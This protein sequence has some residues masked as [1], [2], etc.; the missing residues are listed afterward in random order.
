MSRHIHIKPG[1][2]INVIIS[3]YSASST[4]VPFVT[5]TPA[6]V[7]PSDASNS[8][9]G[10]GPIVL[11]PERIFR[12]QSERHVLVDAD[13][14]RRFLSGIRIDQAFDVH[15]EAV[16]ILPEYEAAVVIHD[17]RVDILAAVVQLAVI[18][19][20]NA[21]WIT[22]SISCFEINHNSSYT[23]KFFCFS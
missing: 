7:S 23:G 6:P 20:T 9:L 10:P 4:N 2:V 13:L 14:Q 11:R 19:E 12:M 21:L 1:I 8:T 16:L 15:V 18:R 5:L 3:S 22:D 17:R